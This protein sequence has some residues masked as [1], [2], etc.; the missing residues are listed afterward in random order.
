[1]RRAPK[2]THGRSPSRRNDDIDVEDNEMVRSVNVG[3]FLRG[4]PGI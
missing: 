3:Q 2:A 4:V 1:M